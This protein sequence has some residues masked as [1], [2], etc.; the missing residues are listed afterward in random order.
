MRVIVQIPCLNEAESL[1]S[2]VARIKALKTPYEIKTLLIDDGS[3]DETKNI[4]RGLF[5]YVLVHKQKLGLARSFHD[6]LKFAVEEGAD[7]VVQIDADLH[8]APEHIPEL[9]L[10]IWQNKAD[11]MLGCRDLQNLAAM[12]VWKKFLQK[13]GS[14]SVSYLIG[15]PIP[16][17]VTGFRAYSAR[18]ARE[19]KNQ[20]K[21]SYTLNT[22]F[23]SYA[24]GHRVSWKVFPAYPVKRKSR[25]AP[26][27]GVYLWKQFLVIAQSLY[28]NSNNFFKQKRKLKQVTASASA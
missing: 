25:L 16:D 14:C 4:A 21:F 2:L 7:I 8:Y 12:P 3:T 11:V 9:I 23:Q 27:T 19:L 18:A 13:A 26:N 17:C 10:A 5:D 22:L 1:E 20:V 24:L 28:L 15:A 6:G